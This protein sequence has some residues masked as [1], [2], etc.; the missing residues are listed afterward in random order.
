MAGALRRIG[1]WVVRGLAALLA[2]AVVAA[3]AIWFLSDRW[4]GKRYTIPT[5]PLVGS[6]TP[7][8]AERGEH[9]ARS[10]LAC[11]QCHGADFGGDKF[12]DSPGFAQIPAPNLTRGQG[13]IGAR[14]EVA[15]WERAIRHG[16]GA[17]G[18]GLLVMPSST[19]SYLADPDLADLVAY[20]ASLPPIDRQFQPRRIGPVA[21][22]ALVMKA[23]E[24]FSA[25]TIAH[26]QV[27]GAIPVFD[28]ARGRGSY[29]A[30]P[31]AGCHAEDFAGRA[32]PIAPDSP[33]PANLTPD[34][35]EGLGK[36]GRDDF[37]R[38]LRTG[39]RP[40]GTEID[41]FMPWR[42]YSGFTDSEVD[43]LWAFLQ[44]LPAK[45]SRRKS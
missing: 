20:L 38:A 4:L 11:T 17:D 19:F 16:V 18:R 2:L 29:L 37:A 9:L 21:R 40:D 45:P 15:D 27:G 36:W 42:A 30:R 6:A 33:P 35:N 22:L 32:E 31:C 34:P 25:E 39:K 13:G 24:L 10:L 28:S 3:A 41:E 8:S 7:P 1:R 14:Y 43:D 44:S 23:K 12:I 5:R 26:A